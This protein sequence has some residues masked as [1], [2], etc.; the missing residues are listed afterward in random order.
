MVERA[1]IDRIAAKR[2]CGA[3]LSWRT[4]MRLVSPTTANSS[5]H[6]ANS[7]SSLARAAF[8]LSL[9]RATNGSSY[10]FRVCHKRWWLLYVRACVCSTVRACVHT[11]CAFYGVTVYTCVWYYHRGLCFRTLEHSNG[12]IEAWQRRGSVTPY[13]RK[14]FLPLFFSRLLTFVSIISQIQP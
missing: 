13:G 5:H 8:R 1:R 11:S 10:M 6:A 2:K 9:S 12:D 14:N 3:P 7:P 4:F